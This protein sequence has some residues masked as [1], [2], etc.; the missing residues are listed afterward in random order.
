MAKKISTSVRINASPEKVWAIFSDFGRYDQ[1]N[2]FI[3]SIAGEVVL[4]A[5]IKVSI[6]PA[7]SRAMKF[8]PQVLAFEEPKTLI[9]MGKLWIK[10][11]F[12]GRHEFHLTD[13][14][15]GSVTFEQNETFSG[16]FTGMVDLETTRQGFELM[17]Q[18]LKSRVEATKESQM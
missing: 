18:T 9:W 13:N 17:N 8:S 6:A 7:G 15:D 14:G 12:D 4:G 3:R 5:R 11:L 1:W 10:G 16:I 2:P